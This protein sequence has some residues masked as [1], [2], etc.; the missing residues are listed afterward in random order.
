MFLASSLCSL[1]LMA[2]LRVSIFTNAWRFSL[3]TMHV[4]TVPKRL[5]TL[6]NSFS[7]HLELFVSGVAVK[8]A[9]A[10]H[11]TPPTKSV[12]LRTLILPCG[13][14]LSNSIYLS[15]DWASSDGLPRP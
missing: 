5:K 13:S 6:R 10:T 9:F 7:E 8:L 14:D 1:A 15:S 2:S 12:R 4:W 3:L 11:V